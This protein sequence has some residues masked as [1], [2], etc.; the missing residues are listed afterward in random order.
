M[1]AIPVIDLAQPSA[2]VA[3]AI[4][5][6]CVE[7][8]F[9]TVINHGVP[10]SLIAKVYAV[11][12][13]FFDLPMAEKMKVARPRPEQ[14]RGFIAL[15][16]EVLSRLA[17]SDSPPDYKEVF[18]I[19]PFDLPATDYYT[20]PA[21]Y[22]HMAPNLWPEQP[23]ALQPV[24]REYWAVL[25]N[26]SHRLLRHC[27]VALELPPGFFDG[28]VD[29]QASMLRLIDYP[30]Y[31]GAARPGQLRAGAHTDLNMLTVLHANST[32]GGLEVR[33]RN[34][35][36]IAP[37]MHADAFV[38]NIGDIMMRWT[39]DRWVSTLHR[40]VNPPEGNTKRRISVPFFFQAN[41]DTIV[42]C[43]PTCRPA[44]AAPK[45]PPVTVGDYRAARFA[46]T[47]NA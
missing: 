44:D 42:E 29:R 23:T 36:W 19:G 13:G 35:H 12:E 15:G 26:L 7:T 43:L 22:P 28:K 6:A 47:A 46:A 14:N 16:A 9:F 32:V 38:V 20:A 34:G 2:A 39:N 24:L 21:A 41:Y 18:T 17:G 10:A 30:P 5:Q 31:S 1:S 45:Y 33:D 11:A 27:A 37:P 40:V 8:G 3:N 25:T 4:G